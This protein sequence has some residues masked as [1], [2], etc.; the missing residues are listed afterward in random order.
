VGGAKRFWRNISDTREGF[1][2]LN[3]DPKPMV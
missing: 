3:I 2:I 1:G